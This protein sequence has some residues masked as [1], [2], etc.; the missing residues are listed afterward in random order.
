MSE[1]KYP[2]TIEDMIAALHD[3]VADGNAPPELPE[4]LEEMLRRINNLEFTLT[5]VLES[6]ADKWPWEEAGG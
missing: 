4:I 3:Q 2:E 5:R 6:R 1:Y